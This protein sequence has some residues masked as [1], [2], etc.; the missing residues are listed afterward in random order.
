MST[1]YFR[2]L[3]VNIRSTAPS[4]STKA[5]IARAIARC[6]SFGSGA[7]LDITALSSATSWEHRIR[8]VQL[9]EASF[10]PG[11]FI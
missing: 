11:H 1:T 5:F 9:R 2:R 6:I 8:L 7:G 10:S 4:S 3:P